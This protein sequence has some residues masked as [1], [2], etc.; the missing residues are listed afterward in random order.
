LRPRDC[1]C[2][3]CIAA[4][5]ACCA[6]DLE[7]PLPFSQGD[8]SASLHPSLYFSFFDFFWNVDLFVTLLLLIDSVMS[9]AEI[10][11]LGSCANRDGLNSSS[12]LFL[13]WLGHGV[14][15]LCSKYISYNHIALINV[16]RGLGV[17]LI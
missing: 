16:Y 5:S 10:F 4:D 9:D 8:A 6:G 17:A 11:L 12:K 13:V 15:F 3:H 7:L 2:A 1:G 14:A